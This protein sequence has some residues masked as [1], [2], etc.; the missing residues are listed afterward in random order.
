MSIRFDPQDIQS[1][2]NNTITPE[3]ANERFTVLI[4]KEKKLKE[5]TICGPKDLTPRSQRELGDL[6]PLIINWEKNPSS[7]TGTRTISWLKDNESYYYVDFGKGE[8]SISKMKE[9]RISDSSKFINSIE[10]MNVSGSG[11]IGV[12]FGDIIKTQYGGKLTNPE[13]INDK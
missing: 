2:R 10:A 9:T 11:N 7:L 6:K 4:D 5:N 13:D 8:T 1:F 3:Q 12:N